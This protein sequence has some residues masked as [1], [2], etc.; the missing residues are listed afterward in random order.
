MGSVCEE[1]RLQVSFVS[2]SPIPLSGC[3]KLARYAGN[4]HLV[5]HS[6][7]KAVE[8]HY[9]EHTSV[10][11]SSQACQVERPSEMGKR[12]QNP[13]TVG[14]N[15]IDLKTRRLT[16]NH[17]DDIITVHTH[18]VR[19]RRAGQGRPLVWLADTFSDGWQPVHDRLAQRYDV[20]IPTYP[21]CAGSSGFED[22]DSMDDLLLHT[23][24]LCSALQ[25]ER[26][27]V[28]GASLGGWLAAEWI[29][30]Y[31]GMVRAA[32]LVD[33][34]GLRVVDA[35]SLDLWRLEGGAVRAAL[36]AAADGPVAQTIMPD[37]P[38]PAALPAFL[39]AR[40][41]L[42]RFAWQFPDNPRL[43]RY[44]YR[45]T[46]PTLIVW[47]EQDG[48]VPTAHGRAY[49]QGICDA[50]LVTLPRCGHLPHLERMEA[51]LATVQDFLGRLG[52]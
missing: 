52:L 40:Q 28:A 12:A 10:L 20:I 5:P 24:D 32:I 41:T 14:R 11:R 25:I 34:L 33:A 16:M 18:H 4:R 17:R 23:L 42:A 35:P 48:L 47:G 31:P 6:Q 39:Q 45:V 21:G 50:Q 22:M 37:A 2:P 26:P 38:T 29:M 7:K 8:K 19:V 49:Q 46:T 36:F 9:L 44:L 3:Y 30:R 1:K 43:G 51:F 27:I 15:F 13:Y